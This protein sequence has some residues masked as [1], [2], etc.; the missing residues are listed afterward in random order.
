MNCLF[1][2]IKVVKE[3]TLS[4]GDILQNSV[5]LIPSAWE[6]PDKVCA[7]IIF[8]SNEYTT[9]NFKITPWLISNNS[10]LKGKEIIIEV[11]YLIENSFLTEEIELL[12]EIG[13]QLK[14]VFEFKLT[15]IL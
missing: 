1:G 11:Y 7:R 3:P 10:A 9:R 4:L 14:A 8:D 15:Y 2:I 6:N 12:K 5:D 13:N